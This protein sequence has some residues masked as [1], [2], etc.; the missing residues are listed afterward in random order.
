MNIRIDEIRDA[1]FS[2]YCPWR[3]TVTSVESTDTGTALQ[4]P[5]GEEVAIS[6]LCQR[7]VQWDNCGKMS[8]ELSDTRHIT[9]YEIGLWETV[10]H[11]FFL[12]IQTAPQP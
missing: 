4:F 3:T 1:G 6:R 9:H 2:A 10:P 11:T 8:T 5:H 12:G 7:S